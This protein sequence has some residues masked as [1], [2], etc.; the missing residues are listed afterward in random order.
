MHTA[1]GGSMSAGADGCP[2]RGQ[3]KI[4][5]L[6]SINKLMSVG[7]PCA[8]FKQQSVGKSEVEV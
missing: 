1:P 4:N 6:Y 7:C 8:I 3:G 5:L 2:A